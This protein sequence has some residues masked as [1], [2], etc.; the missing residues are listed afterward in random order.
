MTSQF[1]TLFRWHVL[2]YVARHKLLALLNVLSVALGVAVYLAIQIANRSANESF[3]A[4][5]DLVAGKAHL[6]ARGQITD[7]LWPKIAK[8][9][10][11]S[12]TTA[13][14]EGVV[15]LP[16]YKGEY[17]RLVGVDVF[18][19]VPFRTFE[20]GSTDQRL[21]TEKWLGEAGS[22]AVT[23][24]FAQ[25]VGL[26][27]GDSL[28]LQV[29]A[30]TVPAKIIA[31]LDLSESVGDSRV[32]A[33]DI[34][35]AQEILGRQGRLNSIQ[36]RAAEPEKAVRLA[37]SIRSV[38]PPDVRVEPPR[39]RSFQMQ[40]ML[41]A[42]QLNLAAMSL[43]SL[44]VGAFLVYN[45]IY[46]S[47]V[48][49]RTELGILRALGVTRTEIRGLFL[50][51][52]CLFGIIGI[53]L[54]SVGG[55][56][57][58]RVMIGAVEK[59]ISSLYMLVSIE[60][61]SLDPWQFVLGAVF[62]I[63][64]VI[65]GA[66]LPANEASQVDPIATLSLAS[67]AEVNPVRQRHWR[68]WAAASLVLAVVL[69]AI[70]LR[71]GPPL[72]AF[73]GA[74]FVLAGFALFA[75]ATT[76]IAGSVGPSIFRD[77]HLL[78]MAGDHLRR[79]LHRHAVTIAALATAVAMMVGLTV[80]I[81]S[82]RESLTTWIEQGVVADLFVAPASNEVI[83]LGSVVPP[84][85]IA[86]LRQQATIDSVDGFREAS[87]TARTREGDQ[88]VLLVAID[89]RYRNNLQF[90]GGN[91]AERM[92]RVFR[93]EAVAVTESLARRWH[94]GAGM[95]LSLVTPKGVE[96]FPIAGVYT[97]YSRDQGAVLMANPRFTQSWQDLGPQ[98][99]A[100]YLKPG[101]NPDQVVDQFLARFS[102]RG[103]F[104]AYSNRALRARIFE[105]F[106][107][108]FAVT[109]VL[110]TIALLVAVIGIFLSVTTVVA[111]RQRETGM[112]RAV[113]ASRGQIA[114]LF[115][116]EAAL[117][118]IAASVLGIITGFALAL[119]LTWVVNPAFFGWTIHLHIPWIAIAT[120]PLWVIAATIFAAWWPAWRGALEPIA[121]SVREE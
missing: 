36:I 78:R 71:F 86:W 23:R 93:G 80:M 14:V 5:V 19:S 90:E 4:G 24:E 61:V 118:G 85:P 69:C 72:L 106:D 28:D 50:G 37:E 115:M 1:P 29:N 17:L 91:A 105:I 13:V 82:F 112:L 70:A 42:F 104:I 74:F 51:E 21:D 76:Q 87:V 83:G 100:V 49:R 35:W 84:E 26:K 7:E 77:W 63:G 60:R 22:I 52:A 11:V 3:A 64:A 88:P 109:Y 27:L 59:T 55:V 58:G 107:Q 20:I 95:T 73:G 114:Q 56:M 54:G 41:S 97:D 32:A 98:S 66:W 65:A 10:G 48:R 96:D 57:L 40:T 99:L 75:P 15:T 62:G 16:A 120:T 67:H 2:R 39:Q 43:V 92:S 101:A 68:W 103:E 94:L 44:L 6:E 47:V 102:L 25:R 108:T 46:A 30:T 79:A 53:V 31:L 12:A 33:I 89:G 34:G 81:Y 121:T 119:V 117:I 8:V 45:T 18:T 9:E 111:E 110:R 38:L 116:T 113:G